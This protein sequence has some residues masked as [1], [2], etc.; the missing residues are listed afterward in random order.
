[1]ELGGKV[2]GLSLKEGIFYKMGWKINRFERISGE[3]APKASISLLRQLVTS[4][5]RIPIKSKEPISVGEQLQLLLRK[6]RL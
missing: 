3:M 6:E 2:E 5:T 1:M 4:S